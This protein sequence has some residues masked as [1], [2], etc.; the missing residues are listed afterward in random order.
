MNP[1]HSLYF[2]YI[3]L[4]N[5]WPANAVAKLVRTPSLRSVQTWND[6]YTNGHWAL[7]KDLSQQPHNA[8]LLG[9]ITFLRPNSAILEIGCGNGALFPY[10]ARLG[11]QRYL[12]ID[13]SS[14]AIDSC[15]RFRDDKTSFKTA[16]A[17]IYAPDFRPDVMLLNESVYYFRE[18]IKTLKRY[19]QHLAPSGILVLSLVDNPKTRT[20]IRCLKSAFPLIDETTVSNSNTAWHCL[21][22]ARLNT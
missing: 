7:L 22:L 15:Q 14:V 16:D 1:L 20:I 8:V 4:H 5:N 10:L 2:R 12:G 19:D 3:F 21:V 6:E 9:Y 13:I 11:Y 18:P 17:E